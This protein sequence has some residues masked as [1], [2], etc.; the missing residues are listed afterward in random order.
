MPVQSLTK[1]PYQQLEWV[2][3]DVLFT[4]R[5]EMSEAFGATTTD[6]FTASLFCFGTT[7]ASTGAGGAPKLLELSSFSP[8]HVLSLAFF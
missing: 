5:V 4:A 1:H 2:F 3:T 7:V 8:C 6:G